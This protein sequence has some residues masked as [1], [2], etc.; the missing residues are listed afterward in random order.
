MYDAKEGETIASFI[1]TAEEYG[2]RRL[3]CSLQVGIPFS[4]VA[5]VGPLSQSSLMHRQIQGS[6]HAT[7]GHNGLKV[8]GAFIFQMS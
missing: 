5:V 1:A 6:K 7:L 2:F 8:R 3:R 4:A